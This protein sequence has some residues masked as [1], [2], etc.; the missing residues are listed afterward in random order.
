MNKHTKLLALVFVLGSCTLLQAT[1]KVVVPN[2]ALIDDWD[3]KHI[4][5][6]YL[7]RFYALPKLQRLLIS[8]SFL[9]DGD[10]ESPSMMYSTFVET[11]IIAGLPYL[12]FYWFYLQGGFGSEWYTH[13]AM[14]A[15][16]LLLYMICSYEWS[17]FKST[18]KATRQLNAKIFEELL[19]KAELAVKQCGGKESLK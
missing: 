11:L 14:D 12:C 18:E 5:K 4:P 2:Q 7:E 19:V 6:E 9:L 13:I 17:L 8:S 1:E 15:G 10:F 3:K 16:G